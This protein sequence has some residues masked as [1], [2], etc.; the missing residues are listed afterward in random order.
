MSA[1]CEQKPG[2]ELTSIRNWTR[3]PI[4]E[5]DFRS[6]YESLLHDGVGSN[7]KDV[8][9]LPLFFVVLAIS[10][11]LSPEHIGGNSQER[12]IRSMRFYWSCEHKLKHVFIVTHC[13]PARRA[14]LISAAIQ[15][16]SLEMVLTRLMVNLIIIFHCLS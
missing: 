13:M 6:S 5:E 3:Y 12:K 2:R 10:V 11:R 7:P 16:D 8:R 1:T 4:S 15:P 14:L 9:F